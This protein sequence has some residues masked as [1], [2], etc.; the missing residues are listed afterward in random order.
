MTIVL[1]GTGNV[2]KLYSRLL[3]T[4]GHR[5]VQVYGRDI[6]KARGLA[7]AWNTAATDRWDHLL[8]DAD[9]YVIAVADSALPH[10][11]ALPAKDRLVV[12]TAGSAGMEVLKNLTG[13]Y[14]I[15]YPLQSI[16]RENMAAAAVPLLLEAA[17]EEDLAILQQLA[18]AMGCPW[19]VCTAADRLRLHV[20]AIWVNNFP[21]L[22][23]SIAYDWCRR[24]NQDFRLLLPLLRETTARLD[25]DSP[26]KWQTGPAIRNDQVTIDKHEELLAPYPFDQALY[27]ELTE[28]IRRFSATVG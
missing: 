21:N 10:L 1:I 18:A 4:T 17:R 14:G 22:L 28:A 9:L 23:F 13:R 5:V 15:L 20:G 8:P 24:E 2:A 3:L 6:T 7:V 12:H 26:W 11:P 19:Q 16:R 25:G 27:R